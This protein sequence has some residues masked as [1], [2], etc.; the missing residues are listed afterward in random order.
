M[1]RQGHMQITF[2]YHK[3]LFVW[4]FIYLFKCFWIIND[5]KWFK[6]IF[7][8]ITDDFNEFFFLLLMILNDLNDCYTLDLI[9]L[10]GNGESRLICVREICAV[11]ETDTSHVSHTH[12]HTHSRCYHV[13]YHQIIGDRITAVSNLMI[14]HVIT[15]HVTVGHE[16]HLNWI[17]FNWNSI[18]SLKIVI[19]FNI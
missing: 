4:L 2:D 16:I 15:S 8:W 12:T 17:I 11:A 19:N 13:M 5:F 6:W 9:E 14:H 3:S 7:F 1:K 10:S 18:K